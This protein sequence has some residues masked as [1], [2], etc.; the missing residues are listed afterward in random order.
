MRIDWALGH[1]WQ[2]FRD[3]EELPFQVVKGDMA[4]DGPV[5][6]RSN[7]RGHGWLYIDIQPEAFSYT[8]REHRK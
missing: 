5:E 7:D 6:L 4:F 1:G 8:E 3:D 2:L